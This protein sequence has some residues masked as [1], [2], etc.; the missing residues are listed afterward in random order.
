MKWN[1]SD[2]VLAFLALSVESAICTLLSLCI[3]NKWLPLWAGIPLLLFV[4]AITAAGLY[5]T[6]RRKEKNG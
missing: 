6:F 3:I 2:Y 1:K 5:C 4:G